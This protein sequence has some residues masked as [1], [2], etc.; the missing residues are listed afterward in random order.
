MSGGDGREDEAVARPVPRPRMQDIADAT[1][2]TVKTVS[3]ALSGAPNVRRSTRERVLA[4]AERLGFRRNDIAAGLRSTGQTMKTLGVVLGDLANPFFPPMLRGIHRVAARNGYLVISAD[5][6]GDAGVE[7]ES[8]QAI[9]A[10]RVAGL[11]I[12]PTG[13]DFGHLAQEARF[14]SAIVFIDSWPPGLTADAVI[15]TNTAGTRTAVTHL[16]GRGHRRI[17]Y[18]GHP[19]RGDGAQKRWL[20]YCQALRHAGIG[21]DD[22]LARRGLTTEADA[23]RAATELLRLDDPPTALFADN[24]RMTVGVLRSPEYALRHPELV[25]FDAFDLAPQLGVSV[26]DSD[27]FQVGSAGAELLFRRLADRGRPPMR[28]TVRARLVVHDRPLFAAVPPPR[29]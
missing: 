21:V 6:Q 4:E 15:T 16:I 24:N 7:R 18:L 3:R 8:I 2:V 23:A 29:E 12:A 28:T 5:A 1:G 19:P 9:L 22:D 27:P 26:V 11:I 10:Q 17:G 13:T 20:G 14:G 25:G